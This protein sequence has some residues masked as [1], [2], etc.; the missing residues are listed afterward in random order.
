MMENI[1]KNRPA[2]HHE[3][4][5]L[6]RSIVHPEGYTV[7]NYLDTYGESMSFDEYFLT[8]KNEA[9]S[10]AYEHIKSISRDELEKL[11]YSA[12]HLHA[13]VDYYF[14]IQGKTLKE[15]S[16]RIKELEERIKNLNKV[17]KDDN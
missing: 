1:F 4:L 5:H 7:D 2:L 17:G 16:E 14:K 13:V 12:L 8:F 11:A 6:I 9:C 10:Y 3:A 15:Y